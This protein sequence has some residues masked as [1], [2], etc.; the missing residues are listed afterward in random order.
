MFNLDFNEL[1]GTG[2]YLI[3]GVI[4]VAIAGLMTLFKNK[5]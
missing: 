4:V 5:E 3:L 2:L 1:S